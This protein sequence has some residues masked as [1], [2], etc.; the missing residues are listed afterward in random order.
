MNTKKISTKLI[1]WGSLIVLV[2][3]AVLGV[4]S[5]MQAAKGVQMIAEETLVG[6]AEDGAKIIANKIEKDLVILD[7]LDEDNDITSMDW[8][9][10]LP[11]LQNIQKEYEFKDVGIADT[12]GWLNLTNGKRVNISDRKYFQ[13]AMQGMP[14]LS[15]PFLNKSDN[16]MVISI[17][18]PIKN[19]NDQIIG[20]IMAS[21]DGKKIC[22]LSN[23]V[24]FGKSGYAYILN[25]TGTTIAHPQYDLVMNMDN[26]IENAKQNS[27]LSELAALQKRMLAGEK[28][29]GSYIYNGI[30]K[31]MSF[32]PI[33]GTDWSLAVTC[34][35]DELLAS[36]D[37]LKKGLF[38]ITIIML[39]IGMAGNYNTGYRI[40]RSIATSVD[41]AK[42]VGQGD[43]SIDVSPLFLKRSDDLGD[44]ARALDQMTQTMRS[45]VTDIKNSTSELAISS[46]GLLSSS[47][48]IAA[49]MQQ[50]SASTEEIAAG[51]E[52][53][54]AAMEEINASSQDININL[55]RVNQ[56][57][58]IGHENARKIEQRALQVQQTSQSSQAAA[59]SMYN[60]IKQKVLQ[61][62][63]ES[64]V[65]DEISGLAENIAG[66][67]DQTNLLAL[68][69]AIEAARAGEQ[70]RGF[71]VVA[72]EVRKLAENSA[73]AVS[74][75]QQLTRQVQSSIA[76]LVNNS[77]SLLQFI[78]DDVVKDY[79]MLVDMSTQYK[80]DADMVTELTETVSAN[81]KNVMNAMQ[82]INRAIDSTSS[83][84]EQT[85]AGA[86]E[87]A[88]GSEQAAGAAVEI[89]A[90]SRKTAD[91]A[92]NLKLMI[93]KFK[94]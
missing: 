30:K 62:I 8:E 59:I 25:Q 18:S 74:G 27:E 83:T 40:S 19:P 24:T 54:S 37:G 34:P 31:E 84:I 41:H 15:D 65:V 12:N 61:A 51:M 22:A 11:I 44:L 53:V 49:T 21:Y 36:L 87:I 4:S 35:T 1:V 7:T 88:R 2:I 39:I 57:A 42:L 63:E 89:S 46:E 50:S 10:Q 70:G 16:T 3:C 94:I 86:Q 48:D 75:I 66:I 47:E 71:A 20:I 45:M 17:A 13:L 6:K 80:Q 5:Y 72:E 52:E 76:N 9:K 92:E 26:T 79:A 23:E 67:A 29:F 69:A 55:S 43:L 64:K 60:E 85:A 91:N 33:P 14:N 81:I 58:E 73:E 90:V 68:N 28:G 38:I 32:A 93:D 56:E 78:N 77:N 82:E